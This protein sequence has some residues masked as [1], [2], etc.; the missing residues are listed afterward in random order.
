[1]DATPEQVWEAIATGPGMDSWFMGRNEIEPRQG[2]RGLW[3][4]GGFTAKS[5]VTAWDP[6]NHF[7]STGDEAPDGSR[8]QF[9]YRVEER[10]EGGSTIRYAHT[11]M[12]VGDW[13][14]EYDAMS[15]G[16]PMYLH[17]LVQ[18]LT[19]FSG[20]FATGV[21][22]QGP[23]VPDRERVMSM[24]KRGLGLP[25]DVAE[26]DEVH[27]MPEGLPA[28]DGV[29]DY[30]SPHFLGVRSSDALYRFI[31]GFEGTTMVGHHL[32]DA[33][34]DQNQAE[35]AWRSWLGRLFDV[36]ATD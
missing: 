27:L 3:S 23:N 30:V 15:E 21:D 36:A 14:A 28:I 24:F 18:Y 1:V 10:E 2:G 16:D 29:V 17:K 31:H 5:T 11:G 20:R 33:G 8:H 4:I 34:V 32:F 13:E 9:D 22:A 12:L 6:P 26:G 25:D 19:Y 35:S 7:V